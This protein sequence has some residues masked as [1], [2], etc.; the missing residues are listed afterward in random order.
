MKALTL[1]QVKDVKEVYAVESG[2]K[3]KTVIVLNDGTEIVETQSGMFK[4]VINFYDTSM[5]VGSEDETMWSKNAKPM[6]SQYGFN[7][8]RS[9]E[10]VKK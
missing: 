9:I 5:A 10:I 2:K 8:I 4:P 7:C 1:N 6:V 3:F